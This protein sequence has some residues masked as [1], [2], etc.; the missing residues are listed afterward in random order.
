MEKI[1]LEIDGMMC[2]MCESH[3][4][5]VIRKNFKIKKVSSSHSK[6]RTEIISEDKIDEDSLK[7]A[8]SDTGYQVITIAYEPY[9]KKGFFGTFRK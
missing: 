9:V 7:K 6:N 2:G 8:I 3:I 4:N 1:I 5:D